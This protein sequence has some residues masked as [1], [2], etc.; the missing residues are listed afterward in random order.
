[1][2]E[3]AANS[4]ER[5]GTEKIPKLM[6]SL[7]LPTIVAQL[8][9][10]L[11]NLVDRMYIGR[12]E[13]TG[14][15]ALTGLGLC[16]P[17]IIIISSFSA[18]VASGGAPLAAIELGRKDTDRAEKILGSGVFLLLCFSAVLTVLFMICKR[19][20]LF[21]FGASDNTIGY[22]E[23]YLSI[24]LLGTIFVQLSM[25]LNTF[26]VAQGRAK[27]AMLS[28]LIGAVTN[29]VLDPIFIFALGMG[30][31]G[32][33][34]A[35]IISQALSAVW[36]LRF[37]I[38]PNSVMRLRLKNLRPNISIILHL[39]ALGVSPFIMVSTESL[40]GIALNAS[41][42]HYGGDLYVG[43]F[44]IL[45]SVMQ[46]TMALL[47]GFTMGVQPIISYNFGARNFERVKKAIRYILTVTFL[48]STVICLICVLFPGLFALI[49]TK[50]EPMI[51]LVKQV[52]PIF[53]AGVW[54]FGLQVGIQSVF[55]GLG[56]AKNS[57]VAAIMRKLV[58][59]IPLVLLLPMR[60]GVMGIYWAEPISDI[61]SVIIVS[62]LF[63]FTYKKV[64]KNQ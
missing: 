31:K 8:I 51:E 37:L 53:F 19:P 6:L 38:S 9:N 60:F 33:A 55:L 13:G 15:L 25:G 20:F 21:A 34:L 29:I 62:I 43:S 1:M 36:I 48:T 18:F 52:L 17:I 35:T 49:F 14:G 57:L 40:V 44:T 26:I 30:V 24:Y 7:A 27:I 54:L 2:A 42:Q 59:L 16:F 63:A 47:Q 61:T 56:Q 10:I 5:L 4:N 11:Y 3:T 32:A 50:E 22:A 45:Q 23:S 12:I 41:L 39:A 64:I 58:L 46:I 28:I